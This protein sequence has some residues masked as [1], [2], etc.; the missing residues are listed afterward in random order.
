MKILGTNQSIVHQDILP[1]YLQTKRQMS[2]LQNQMDQLIQ[3]N[4]QL[5]LENEELKSNSV[6]VKSFCANCDTHS[7]VE[8]EFDNDS[9]LYQKIFDKNIDQPKKK[10]ENH[11]APISSELQPPMVNPLF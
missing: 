9:I 2:Q 5:L 7:L 10:E 1:L 11:W 6:C 4:N 8:S 3:T